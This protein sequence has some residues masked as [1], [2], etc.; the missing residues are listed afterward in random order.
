MSSNSFDFPSN[1]LTFTTKCNKAQT[2]ILTGL[3]VMQQPT[4]TPQL[5][6]VY[7]F[8]M[9]PSCFSFYHSGSAHLCVHLCA[10]MHIYMAHTSSMYS[11]GRGAP[12]D[13][14]KHTKKTK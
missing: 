9:S 8:V 4:T 1:G 3:E 14:W 12:A 10:F 13:T 2:I 7:T 11:L 6:N 5:K